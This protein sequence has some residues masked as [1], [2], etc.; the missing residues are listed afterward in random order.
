MS[1]KTAK[2]VLRKLLKSPNKK[3]IKCDMELNGHKFRTEVHITDFFN[4]LIYAKI[5]FPNRY[6]RLYFN[7]IT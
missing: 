5:P 4:K 2:Q 7:Y 3:L 6:I 1:Q